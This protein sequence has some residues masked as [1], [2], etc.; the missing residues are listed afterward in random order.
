MSQSELL[1]EYPWLISPAHLG[2][3]TWDWW[4]TP[5]HLAELNRALVGVYEG[6]SPRLMVNMPQQ[7]GKSQLA[8]RCY[9]A[10]HLLRNPNA[11]FLIV[12]HESHP[13]EVSYGLAIKDIFN[14]W[15]KHL[16]LHIRED[17]KRKGEW[18]IDGAEGGVVCKGWRGGIAGRP[19]DV[20]L[21]DDLITTPDMAL[22]SVLMDSHWRFVDNIVVGRVQR[23]GAAL[24]MVGTRWSKNDVFGRMLRKAARTGQQWKHLK[25][26]AV[27]K[28][29]DPL[30]RKPGQTLW[31]K[32]V[33][34]DEIRRQEREG[35]RWFQAAWQQEPDAEGGNLFRPGSWPSWADVG[36]AVSLEKQGG[37]RELYSW[38]DILRV[39]VVDWATSEKKKSDFTAKGCFGLVPDGRMLVLQT[40]QR[41]IKLED[42]VA[43]LGAFCKM[44]R[45][46]LCVMEAGGFQTALAIEC[47]RHPAIPPLRQ[48]KPQGRSKLMRAYPAIV[49]GEN[50]R[51]LLPD[52]TVSSTT[53]NVA[54][55]YQDQWSWLDEYIAQLEGFD[56]VTDGFDD[57]IDMTAYAAQEALVLFGHG[58]PLTEANAPCMLTAGKNMTG[59]PG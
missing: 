54:D 45:P 18:K 56:G 31:P 14:R 49:M 47:A 53:T 33:S 27:A 44:W 34:E 32:K 25:F 12:G 48:V 41:R 11:R 6:L 13:T 2:H 58:R 17:M 7:F 57:L 36:H 21:I 3:A 15:G 16:G 59:Y 55:G 24:I 20:F 8:T 43:E 26:A 30:G 10:W 42:A 4:E 19:A 5:P 29:N 51:I 46:S 52:P 39:V 37:G 1:R 40:E 23:V 28:K 38:D 35:G 9:P 50:G 22:S